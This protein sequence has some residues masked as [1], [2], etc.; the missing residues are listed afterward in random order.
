[1]KTIWNYLCDRAAE[2]P[3]KTAISYKQG[4]RIIHVTFSQFKK[5]VSS[6]ASHLL[7]S[8]LSRQKIILMS[9]NTYPFL[10]AA[11]GIMAAGNILIPLD[12]RMNQ[13]SI[14]DI[15]ARLQPDHILR[16]SDISRIIEKSVP[17]PE[18]TSDPA[19]TA[20]IMFTSGS[21]GVSK[22]VC[23]TQNNLIANAVSSVEH[24]QISAD[25]FRNLICLPM[26]HIFCFAVDVMWVVIK[27]CPLALNTSVVRIKDELKEFGCS[28]V[29]MVP[30][31]AEVLLTALD[32]EARNHPETDRN[33]IRKN[34][35]GDCFRRIIL[36]G[37]FIEPKLRDG[38]LSYG[39][40]V[41]CGYGMTETTGPVSSEE[42]AGARAGSVGDILPCNEVK[43][44]DNEI[45][46]RG[47]NVMQGYYNDEQTTAEH[48]QDGW[49]KTGDYGYIRDH[50]LYITGKK[51]NLIITSNGEN[52]SPEELEKYLHESPMVREVICF[53]KDDQ[54]QAVI[55]PDME[56]YSEKNLDEWVKSVNQRLPMFKQ[57]RKYS[58]TDKELEKT[59]SMKI[60]RESYLF[61]T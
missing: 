16:C 38:L 46:I 24:A 7:S 35:L 25:S 1:M 33:D 37:A 39:I 52:V 5:D 41:I 17:A 60:K 9:E 27:G 10:I 26:H 48:L 56:I 14:N 12:A 49:L 32:T 51:K 11:F 3:D 59:S 19:E 8:G 54:I 57:I 55:Y 22:G 18:L 53:Q 50:Y 44:I 20:M 36:G 28:R 29:C 2:S 40:E 34:V 15:T 47:S 21:T 45:C 31:M 13:E 61:G 43:I 23:L 4:D 58:V 6:L 30:M 42:G